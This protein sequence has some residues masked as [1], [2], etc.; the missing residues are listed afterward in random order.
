MFM[1]A[2]VTMVDN[3]QKTSDVENFPGFPEPISGYDLVRS[4]DVVLI[5]TLKRAKEIIGRTY[6]STM[7]KSR[8]K[9]VA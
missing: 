5:T 9:D 3:F 4:D 8:G 2:L 6:V 7:S 1:F